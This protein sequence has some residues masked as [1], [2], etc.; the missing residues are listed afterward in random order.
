MAVLLP[1][2]ATHGPLARGLQPLPHCAF[3]VRGLGPW[4]PSEGSQEQLSPRAEGWGHAV[5]S[6]SCSGGFPC[7][8][9][10]LSAVCW[11]LPGS[12]RCLLIFPTAPGLSSLLAPGLTPGWFWGRWLCPLARSSRRGW[13]PASRVAWG[14]PTPT[15]TCGLVCPAS[16]ATVVDGDLSGLGEGHCSLAFYCR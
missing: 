9:G 15:H 13:A 11:L 5:T 2:P 6:V 3:Q 16:M 14:C 7:C 10:A 12:C 4:L 1:P 8:S